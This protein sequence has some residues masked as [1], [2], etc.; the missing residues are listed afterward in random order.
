MKGEIA[1]LKNQTGKNIIAWGG[2]N[3]APDLINL[4]LVDEIRI[5]LNS[6]V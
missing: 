3:F 2:S 5:E 4:E 1:S 6:T